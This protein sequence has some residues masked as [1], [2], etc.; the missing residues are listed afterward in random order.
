MSTDTYEGASSHGRP[1]EILDLNYVSLYIED[2]SEAI[3]FYEQVFGPP[4]T[5]DEAG[6]IYGWRMGATWLTLF[7]SEQGSYKG[8]NPR[9][10]EFAI[11]VSKPEEV[12]VLYELLLNAGAKSC[13]APEDT[14][15]YEDMRFS[16]VDDPFGVRIDIYG[17]LDNTTN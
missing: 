15:M 14:N 3:E 4:E 8:S 17:L 9:N 10:A 12:D 16:C 2:F 5:V 6:G 7:P 1:Y 13:W 11:Q